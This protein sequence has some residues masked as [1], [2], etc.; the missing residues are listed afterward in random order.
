MIT[1]VQGTEKKIDT[2]SANNLLVH[3]ST[4]RAE[5]KP[6]GLRVGMR[7]LGRDDGLY[8]QTMFQPL[9]LLTAEHLSAGS[10]NI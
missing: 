5:C 1:T 7:F 6:K 10:A 2:T 9:N 4:Y 3:M 8:S